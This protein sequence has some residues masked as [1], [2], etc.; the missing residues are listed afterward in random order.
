[1]P[2]RTVRPNPRNL[3]GFTLVELLVVIGILA[4]LIGILLP[5]LNR[6]RH[7]ARTLQCQAN[8]RQICIGM[9]EYE[10]ESKGR[11]PP[12][13]SNLRCYWFDDRR[14]GGILS[15]DLANKNGVFT[16]PEDSD[17]RRSYSMNAW[18][19]SLLGNEFTDPNPGTGVLWPATVP[20]S[21]E[22]I[23]I[24]EAWS[25][26]DD[27]SYG[28]TAPE[29]VG[30]A[31]ATP[32]RRFGAGGGIAPLWD[33]GRFGMVNSQLAYARHRRANGKG[34]GTEPFGVVNIGYADGHVAGR[35]EGELAN[36]TTGKSHLQSLWSPLDS[37]QEQ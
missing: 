15:K 14:V 31:G 19:S 36:F 34:H 29:V 12:N 27:P 25:E 18:T 6:A 2:Q 5:A 37:S 32:G 10:S 16:C 35:A 9:V 17:A 13:A 21:S 23:L 30:V 1:M 3:R 11:R 20:R 26:R 24:I 8:L 28:Y 33:A 4:M 22:V 7:Q